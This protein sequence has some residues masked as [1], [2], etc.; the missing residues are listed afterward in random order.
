MTTQLMTRAEV[1]TLFQCDYSTT[2]RVRGLD[3]CRAIVPG[4]KM[5]RFDRDKVLALLQKK[6]KAA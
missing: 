6:N 2:Y 3:A 1:A 5:V 4:T